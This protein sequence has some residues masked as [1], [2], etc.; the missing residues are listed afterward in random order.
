MAD[1]SLSDVVYVD[2]YEVR[3]EKTGEV[4]ILPTEE[5]IEERRQS[6]ALMEEDADGMEGD[7]A[8]AGSRIALR[9]A[10]QNER[11]FAEKMEKIR[12]S[13]EAGAMRHR[14]AIRRPTYGEY[15]KS[16]LGATVIDSVSGVVRVDQP[17]VVDSLFPTAVLSEAGE[18]VDVDGLSAP[19]GIYLRTRFHQMLFPNQARLLFFSTRSGK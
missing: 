6:A 14:F 16:E 8:K 12:A 3:N 10:A 7:D 5:E 4:V 13:L 2:V 11:L 19:I 1:T 15:R 18:R 17:T 9:D